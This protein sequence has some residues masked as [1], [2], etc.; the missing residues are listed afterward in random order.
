MVTMAFGRQAKLGA[1]VKKEHREALANIKTSLRYYKVVL[2]SG[3]LD[4]R[5]LDFHNAIYLTGLMS[6]VESFVTNLATEILLS[7]PDKLRNSDIK[8]KDAFQGAS[9]YSLIDRSVERQVTTQVY[10]GF[11]EMTAE[12]AKLFERRPFADL[13]IE[14]VAELKATRDVYVH[15]QGRVNER[16]LA[17]AGSKARKERIGDRLPLTREYLLGG[18]RSIEQFLHAFYKHGPKK[19]ERY[20]K[21]RA[22]KAMWNETALSTV[23]PFE[24][25]WRVVN[26]DLVRPKELATGWAWSH[27]EKPLYDFFLAVYSVGNPHRQADVIE[28]LARWPAQTKE[29]QV[30]ISWMDDPFFF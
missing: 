7:F 10:A 21:A 11:T 22:F 8:L 9:I 13:S 15:N 16:Y 17:K 23:L 20:G 29:G 24:D 28:A 25:A 4:Q 30:I 14:E 6:I 3:A 2:A 27:S 19:F 26:D 18:A 1:Y 12:I 5:L